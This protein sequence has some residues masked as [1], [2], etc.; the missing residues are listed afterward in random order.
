[1]NPL[2]YFNYAQH[3]EQLKYRS[4]NESAL[5]LEADAN[6]AKALDQVKSGANGGAF[7]PQWKQLTNSISTAVD[8]GTKTGTVMVKHDNGTDMVSITWSSNA[9]NQVTLSVAGEQAASAQTGN[10]TPVPTG[11]AYPDSALQ[12]D[13]DTIV[14]DL[15]GLVTGSNIKS[16]IA[17]LKKY[18]GKAGLRDD[19]RTQCDAVGRLM[20]LYKRDENG[21]TLSGDIDSIGTLTLSADDQK[22]LG[23]LKALVKPYIGKE[24]SFA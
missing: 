21:D 20:L 18:A 15:D 7:A 12:P 8:A 17:I 16:I 23:N 6:P 11:N 22:Q 14:D 4:V 13:V 1:M 19:D 2:N 9:Q 10:A 5:V 24:D 3:L